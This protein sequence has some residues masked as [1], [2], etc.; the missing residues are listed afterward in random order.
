MYFLPQ[1]IYSLRSE[2]NGWVKR[3][4]NKN[5]WFTI[6]KGELDY[7]RK[8]ILIPIFNKFVKKH[9]LVS[10]FTY[11]KVLSDFTEYLEVFLNEVRKYAIVAHS[12]NMAS[13]NINPPTLSEIDQISL[14]SLSVRSSVSHEPASPGINSYQGSRR[15]SK[16]VERKN[17]LLTAQALIGVDDT[18]GSIHKRGSISAKDEEI[19]SVMQCM[20]IQSLVLT[21]EGILNDKYKVDFESYMVRYIQICTQMHTPK[22]AKNLSTMIT[23][24]RESESKFTLFN[25]YFSLTDSR[26]KPFADYQCNFDTEITASFTNEELSTLERRRLQFKISDNSPNLRRF[27]MNQNLKNQSAMYRIQTSIDPYFYASSSKKKAFYVVEHLASYKK[28][29]L[30]I[31]S[32]QQGKSSFIRYLSQRFFTTKIAMSQDINKSQ[33]RLTRAK[34]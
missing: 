33:V 12:R 18:K 14:P 30:L 25:Y 22:F 34:Y 10:Q 20:Y 29:V 13:I 26:W 9:K 5:P 8:T 17:Q 4:I 32:A 16:M 23:K 2:Y 11:R 19:I 28:D 24:K 15:M 1:N 21:M 3:L 6:I 7:L 27:S 31:S